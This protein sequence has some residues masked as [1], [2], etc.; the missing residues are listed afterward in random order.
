M[1]SLIINNT[2]IFSLK[3]VSVE[4]GYDNDQIFLIH[5]VTKI[6]VI[7]HRQY[8]SQLGVFSIVDM[9]VQLE[10]KVNDYY[11]E[12]KQ[13]FSSKVEIRHNETSSLV[14]ENI[15]AS[16]NQ[17]KEIVLNVSSGLTDLTDLDILDDEYFKKRYSDERQQELRI[18]A[19]ELAVQEIDNMGCNNSVDRER[20][21][22][23]AANRFYN[24]IT[25][26]E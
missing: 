20:L 12:K 24:Y 6:K 23:N 13:E 1:E 5:S 7:L 9:L 25:K 15:S 10:S 26:G 14:R 17:Q 19:L 4:E 8:F 2:E 21:M 11:K 18:K 22:F 3:N 16:E